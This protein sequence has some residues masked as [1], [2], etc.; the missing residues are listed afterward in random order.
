MLIP[1]MQF[2]VLNACYNMTVLQ[3]IIFLS[4]NN[5]FFNEFYNNLWLIW[6]IR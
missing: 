3:K 2:F 5:F 6:Y 1:L 4:F